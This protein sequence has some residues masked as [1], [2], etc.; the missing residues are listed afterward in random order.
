MACCS[1]LIMCDVMDIRLRNYLIVI[2]RLEHK[3]RIRMTGMME[4]FTSC[5]HGAVVVEVTQ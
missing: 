3:F 2:V 1:H 5:A 4:R